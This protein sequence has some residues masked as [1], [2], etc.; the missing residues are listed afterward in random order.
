MQPCGQPQ[1]WPAPSPVQERRGVLEKQAAAQ[2]AQRDAVAT[3]RQLRSRLDAL[4]R[5]LQGLQV[6]RMVAG[7]GAELDEQSWGQVDRQM[8]PAA[9]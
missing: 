2:Q 6:S 3:K 4:K 9:V 7:W 1:P 5:E 8:W